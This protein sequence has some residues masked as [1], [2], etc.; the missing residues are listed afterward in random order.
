[1]H[2]LS[3][4]RSLIATLE[5]E[6]DARGLTH[7]LGVELGIGCLCCVEPEALRFAFET[8]AKP[9]CLEA[10]A[11]TIRRQP[12]RAR[13]LA[14]GR[15]YEVYRWLDACPACA[16]EARDLAGGDELIIEQME[17]R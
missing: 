15:H 1:M 16:G 17:A 8:V 14:C 9:A 12:A 11:L 7:I 10:C 3:L 6:A 2:E 5:R 4:C 13:C